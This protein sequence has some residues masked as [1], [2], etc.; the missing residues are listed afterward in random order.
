MILSMHYNIDVDTER[1]IAVSKIYGIWKAELAREYHDEYKKTVNPLL[2]GGWARLTNLTNWKSSYP[3]IVD[4]IGKHM[5]WCFENGAV[6]SAYVIE[7]PTTRN[8]LN[9]MIQ[10]GTAKDFSRVFSTVKD[11]D[12]YLQSK[13]F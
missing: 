7:N 3:E 1:K 9:R 5:R 11:A 10:S 4:I 8:Q 13:G 12:K 6:C 2:G